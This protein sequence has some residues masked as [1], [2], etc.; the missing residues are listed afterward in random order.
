MDEL[1]MSLEQKQIFGEEAE[2]FILQFEHDRLKG[3]KEI[4]WVA[5]Y[6]VAEGYDIASYNDEN[7]QTTDRF[8]EVKSFVNELSFYWSRNEIDIAKVKKENYYLYLVDRSKIKNKD[9]KPII[10]QNP[11]MKILKNNVILET[12]VADKRYYDK[13]MKILSFCKTKNQ[14]LA[15]F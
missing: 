4:I 1:Q 12:D 8:I 10:I 14:I 5:E 7:P 2:K 11:Y 9:Y 15:Q 3:I 6:S 13:K